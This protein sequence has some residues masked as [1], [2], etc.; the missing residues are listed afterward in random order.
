MG[1]INFCVVCGS[2]VPADSGTM[3]EGPGGVEIICDECLRIE[4]SCDNS[5]S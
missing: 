1:D 3:R 5:E 4:K 2:W